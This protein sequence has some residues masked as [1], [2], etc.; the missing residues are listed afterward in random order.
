MKLN[1]KQSLGLAIVSCL[2]LASSALA[3]GNGNGETVATL[4]TATVV[5]KLGGVDVDARLQER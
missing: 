1:L 3:A 2:G 5:R 4:G